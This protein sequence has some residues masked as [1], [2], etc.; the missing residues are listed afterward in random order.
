MVVHRVGGLFGVLVF[1][2][3]MAVPA[4]AAGGTFQNPVHGRDFPD[5]FVLHVGDTYYAYA[6]NAGGINVQTAVSRDL[7][8]W[9]AG[10]DAL[11]ALPSWSS[12]GLTWAPTVLRRGDGTYL[13]YYTA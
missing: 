4:A 8:H 13:L 9:T 7:V 3:V 5:P 11:P 10:P 1:C 6:T 12:T 2:L